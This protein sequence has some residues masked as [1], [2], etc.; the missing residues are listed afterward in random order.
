M[1]CLSSSVVKLIEEQNLPFP[2]RLEEL[3]WPA[4]ASLTQSGEPV[5]LLPVGATEQHGK[6]LP[7]NTDTCI[8]TAVC[9]YASSLSGAYVAPPQAY[10]VSVGHTSKWPGTFS[11]SHETLITLI[12]EWVAWAVAMGWR[13]VLLVNSHFGNDAPLRVALDKARL[14][15]IG[16]L[17]IGLVNTFKVSPEIWNYFC[18]DAED[19]HANKAETDL[20]LFLSPDTVDTDS[21]HDDP[22]RT[23]GTVFSYP[24]AQTSLH[25]LTGSPSQG[26]AAKGRSLFMQMSEALAA[27]VETANSEQPP[28]DPSHWNELSSATT[29]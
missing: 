29:C 1:N 17:Q 9:D 8:A 18:S 16:A 5:L 24:V 6:H 15:H 13:R 4:I 20:M 19:L 25:G 12:G 21:I 22:D 2:H 14:N 3:T 11:L 26:T 27:L 28:L 23:V 10:S 7:I